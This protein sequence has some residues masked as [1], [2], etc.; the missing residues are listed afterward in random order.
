MSQ[1]SWWKTDN[2]TQVVL[3]D[4]AMLAAMRE[5]YENC[6]IDEVVDNEPPEQAQ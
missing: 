2:G 1:Y 5:A 3:D 6:F 4:K